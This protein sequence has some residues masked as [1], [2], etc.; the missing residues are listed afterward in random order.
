MSKTLHI[1]SDHAGYELKEAVSA[2]LAKQSYTLVD[3]GTSDLQSCDY[4]VFAQSLCKAVLESGAPGILICGTGIGMSVAANRFSGIRAALCGNEFLARA[5]RQHN[6]ANVL[7]LGSRV[8]GHG[9]ALGIVDAFL[10]T[11]FEGGR[12]EKRVAMLET[13]V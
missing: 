6:N 1:A 13:G 5:C 12:H 9:L 10:E 2:H 4:P 11:P 8:I 7:C 3:H